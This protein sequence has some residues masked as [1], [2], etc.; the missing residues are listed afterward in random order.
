MAEIVGLTGQ[1]AQGCLFAQQFLDDAKTAP[2]DLRKLKTEV[3]LVGT[4]VR[5][6]E[7]IIWQAQELGVEVDNNEYD[8]ALQHCVDVVQSLGNTLEKQCKVFATDHKWWERMKVPA[9]EKLLDEEIQKLESTKMQLHMVQ[10]NVS[11]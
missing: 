3:E 7:K 8:A 5:S 10:I 1:I 2:E 6:T 11:L 9:R 4:T